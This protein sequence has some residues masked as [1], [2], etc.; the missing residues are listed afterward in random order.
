[1]QRSA[2]STFHE[3]TFIAPSSREVAKARLSERLLLIR[4]DDLALRQHVSARCV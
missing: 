3:I 1:M 2:F 4:A